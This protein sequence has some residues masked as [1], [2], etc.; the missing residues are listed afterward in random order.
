MRRAGCGRWRGWVRG[1]E[2]C[3][4]SWCSRFAG[5]GTSACGRQHGLAGLRRRSAS[6][7]RS[8]VRSPECGDPLPDDGRRPLRDRW[9]ALFDAVRMTKVRAAA[10]VYANGA[11]EQPAV[12]GHNDLPGVLLGSAAQRLVS[13]TRSNLA[14]AWWC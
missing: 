13:C 6:A 1:G 14:T 2:G 10:V 8:S 7:R 11:I 9:V 12:F 4:R 3:G 5:R